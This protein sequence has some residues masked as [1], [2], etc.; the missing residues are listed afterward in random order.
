MNLQDFFRKKIYSPEELIQIRQKLKEQGKTVATI[1]GS[2]DLMHAGHLYILFEAAKQA[3]ILIVALN[4][5]ASIKR[6]KGPDRPI[7]DLENRMKMVASIEFVNLVSWFDEDDPRQ[8]LEKIQPDIHVNGAEYGAEC[9]E[10]Q[11]V[12]KHGGKL[13]LV[14]R[15]PGLASSQILKKIKSL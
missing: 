10:A 13:H 15:I 3:D 1:N 8:F 7:I 11:V 4:S 9:V 14:K 6:Y 5:D 2:F 12:K